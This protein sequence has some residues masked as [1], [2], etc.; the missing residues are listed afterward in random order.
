MNFL[1]YSVYSMNIFF[2]C[3]SVAQLCLTL[4][5]PMNCS[6]SGLSVPHHLPK[7]AQVHVH[8]IGDAIQ[9]SHPLTPTSTSAFSFSQHQ[10]LFPMNQLFTSDD[11]NTRV[12][13]SASVLPVS[14]QGWFPLRLTG[15]ISL[16]SKGLSGV[17]SST[18]I[19]RHQFFGA[20][21]YLQSSSHDHMCCCCC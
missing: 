1:D 2:C 14:I 17:F 18:T 21:P 15:L 7:F 12:S 8:C 6:T 10:V 11:Q 5:T 19:W 20:L 4:C 9:P 16:L 3:C 13:A